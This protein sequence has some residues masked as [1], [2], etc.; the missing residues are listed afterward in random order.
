MH[1]IKIFL[2]IASAILGIESSCTTETTTTINPLDYCQQNYGRRLNST[3]LSYAYYLASYNV[4][5]VDQSPGPCC[6]LCHQTMNC[7]Y[8]YQQDLIGLNSQC[9]LYEF[10][11]TPQNFVMN[12]L[13]GKYYLRKP[14]GTP[15]VYKT[16]SIGYNNNFMIL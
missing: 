2:I 9:F 1:S 4:T 7:D 3:A 13:K 15:I 11:N 10:K 12:I 6:L 16:D 14:N 8:Y 5:S